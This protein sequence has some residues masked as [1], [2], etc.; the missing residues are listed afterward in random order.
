MKKKGIINV[1]FH[2]GQIFKRIKEKEKFA[3]LVS[4]LGIPKTTIILKIDVF[5]LCEKQ[6]KLLK[7]SI[8]LEFFKN[9]NK[10]IKAI[11]KEKEEDFQ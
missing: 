4:V 8:G 7:S 10:D 6:R 1:A 11:S 3:K 2:Q 9:Y 5:K